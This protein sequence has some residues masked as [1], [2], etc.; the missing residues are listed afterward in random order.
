MQKELVAA[1]G[2]ESPTAA[3]RWICIMVLPPDCPAYIKRFSHLSPCFVRS[4]SAGSSAF[5][6]QPP[7]VSKTAWLPK[8][9]KGKN[10]DTKKSK[11]SSLRSGNGPLTTKRLRALNMEDP[12][13]TVVENIKDL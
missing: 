5:W 1:S 9:K 2:P 4:C 7:V 13:K 3:H 10:Q 12:A 6:R 8:P 11:G